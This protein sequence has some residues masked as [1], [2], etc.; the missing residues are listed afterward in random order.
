MSTRQPVAGVSDA[1]RR[2]ASGRLRPWDADAW[3]YAG[4]VVVGAVLVVVT[5][6]RQPFSYDEISQITPYSSWN[7][8]DVV[9]GTRQ[10]PLDPLLGSL[11]T[12]VFGVGQLQQR[13]VPVL[14]AIGIFV[15]LSLLFRRLGLGRA[16]AW[17]V[18]V[19]ATAPLMVR[20]GAYTRPYALPMF[21]MVLFAYAL[22][23]WLHERDRRWFRVLV[24]TAVALP[25]TRVPE[26][27]VFLV[28]TALSL[29]WAVRR[30]HLAR[31]EVKPVVVTCGVVFLV[32]ALPLFLLLGSETSSNFFDPSP[33]GVLSR[34]G[35]GVHEMVT[36][37]VPLLG[38]SFPWWPLS[39]AVVV[40]AL[41]VGPS[42]RW[43][44]RWPMWWPFI[45]AP[46]AFLLAYHLVNK[47]SFFALPY[48]ARASFFFMPAYIF[49]TAALASVVARRPR[50]ALPWRAALAV[51]LAATLLSQLPAT[52]RVVIENSAPDFGEASRV[53]TSQVPDDAIVLYDRPT[54]AGQ[55]RQP[56][57]GTPRYMGHT[58]Y[59]QDVDEV[60]AHAGDLPSSGP[61]YVLV[62]GQCARPGRCVV[63][64]SPWTPHVPGWRLMRTMER[65]SLYA[66]A[67]QQSGLTG[68]VAAMKAFGDALGPELG[69]VETLSAASLLEQQGHHQE[70]VAIAGRLRARVP[71]VVRERI[72]QWV[73]A[74]GE[75]LAGLWR[76][77]GRA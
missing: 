62:N 26:P 1:S 21:E 23:R 33:G 34:F 30:G 67:H 20:Y 32:L 9:T 45:A 41:L 47:F 18:W 37:A 42:R 60:A 5:A 14:S 56:F 31:R 70:A 7:V 29:A 74:R 22:H 72:D 77:A 43:L 17:A 51:L 40:L 64:R 44:L 2:T 46:V 69:Y 16:G 36:A 3:W 65:F 15:V 38:T 35:R 27:T 4:A 75:P 48:R 58:P 66:P 55:S 57:L 8:V 19:M 68:V 73:Q 28:V 76:A 49:V 52:A 11:L 13:L 63:S 39:L 12:H 6:V 50:V 53:L 54:P 71:P 61:V 25:L 10:P 24:G 59:V